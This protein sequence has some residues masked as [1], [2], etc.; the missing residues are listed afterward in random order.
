[1]YENVVFI[2]VGTDVV[3]YSGMGHTG[4]TGVVTG[5]VRFGLSAEEERE[6]MELPEE[7]ETR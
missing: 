7:M 1:M 4:R 2:D 6:E 5:R 3:H